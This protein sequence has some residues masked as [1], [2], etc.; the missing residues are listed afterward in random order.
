MIRRPLINKQA[1]G[2]KITNAKLPMPNG[3][4]PIPNCANFHL[5]LGTGNCVHQAKTSWYSFFL[6]I[7][8]FVKVQ[9]GMILMLCERAYSTA[10]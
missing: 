9:S 7:T 10:V 3:K 2:E 6:S 8:D 5:P 4:C 1:G